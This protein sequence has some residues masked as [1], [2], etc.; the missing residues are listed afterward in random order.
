MEK[1][2]QKIA[3]VINGLQVIFVVKQ[4]EDALIV[5]L[6]IMELIVNHYVIQHVKRIYVVQL[7]QIISQNLI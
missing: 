6:A 1:I 4:K 5:N 7:N 3:I 2:V